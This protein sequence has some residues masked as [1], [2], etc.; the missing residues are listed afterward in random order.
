MSLSLSLSMCFSSCSKDP[1][2]A[3]LLVRPHPKNP[4]R[5]QIVLLDHG[6]Y[7]TLEE[8]FRKD[9]TRLWQAMILADDRRIE[10]YSRRLNVGEFYTMLATVLTMKSWDHIV[11]QDSD[12]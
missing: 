11:T 8:S 5:P 6:L 3:N 12:K 7:R 10:E 4:K 2:E 1:H 9:Y